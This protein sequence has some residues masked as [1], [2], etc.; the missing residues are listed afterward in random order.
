[1]P[2]QAVATRPG[3]GDKPLALKDTPPA[4]LA[5]VPV[6]LND[7]LTRNP[8]EGI[9]EARFSAA[10]CAIL[11][12]PVNDEQ[13]EIRGHDGLIYFPGVEFRKRLN[14]AFGP[15][16]WGM[17]PRGITMHGNVMCY[18]GAL[19]ILGR[20]VSESIGEAKYVANNPQVSYAS[21]V[22]AA[23]TDCLTR[24]CKDLGIAAEL[25]EPAF[26]R[27]WVA[28]HAEKDRTGKWHRKEQSFTPPRDDAPVDVEM[29][30]DQRPTT[31][32]EPVRDGAVISDAQRRRLFTIASQAGHTHEQIKE[33]LASLYGY[34]SSKD[35]R[36][37]DY[38]RLCDRLIDRKPLSE[39]LEPGEPP[40]ADDARE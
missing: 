36:T 25:W 5:A 30:E 13:I 19:F 26:A 10:A 34:A 33:W 18:K 29:I 27:R 6:A 24:C 8:Y 22:E 3:P 7:E 11:T 17:H 23:K 4:P 38:D 1:M 2:E 16:A 31:R 40:P 14:A 15:G 12:A 21:A 32:A 28:A 37:S 9:A 39:D 35:I 20:F